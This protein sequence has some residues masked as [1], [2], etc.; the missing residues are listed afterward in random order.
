VGCGGDRDAGK[1]SIMGK[2]AATYSDIVI[3]T[4]DNPR[5]ENPADIRAEMMVSAP[6]A[7]EIG[8]RREAIIW[9]I[10]EMKDGDVLVIA[11]KGHEQGQII[12]NKTEIFN[13][14]GKFN[15][16]QSAFLL[17]ESKAVFTHDTGLMHIASAFKKEI[18]SIWGNTVPEFG[19][20]PYQTKFTIYENKNLDCRPCSKIGFDKCPKGH[21]KCMNDQVFDIYFPNEE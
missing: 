5:S 2:I 10:E 12:G 17:K 18:F 14:C 11:G 21:F 9:A 15:L 1:R 13:G 3:I 16:N 6:D 7:K 20:Y 4:D 19:M 8:G